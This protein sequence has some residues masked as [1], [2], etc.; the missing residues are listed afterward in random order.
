MTDHEEPVGAKKTLV[1]LLLDRSGSMQAHKDDTLGAINAYLEE[2]KNA[3]GD[4]RFSMVQFDASAEGMRLETTYE[5]RRIADVPPLRA[6]AFRPRGAT[7]LLDAAFTTIQAVTEQTS[8]RDDIR[9]VLAIQTDGHENASKEASWAALKRLVEE[10][11]EAGWEFVF[12]GA[13]IDAYEQSSMMGISRERTMSYGTDSRETNAAFAA[14]AQNTV[15]YVSGRMASLEF[16][17]E[18]KLRS[19]DRFSRSERQDDELPLHLKLR[20]WRIER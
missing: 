15:D 9:I 12:M 8:G 16:S 4:L 13:G 3:E 20:G 2:L 6:D 19:G 7:P 1:T 5:C 18:Q 10:K 11:E 17:P 14:M